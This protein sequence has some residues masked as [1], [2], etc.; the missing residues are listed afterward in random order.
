MIKV[1]AEE[2]E[3]MRTHIRNVAESMGRPF[4]YLDI[5]DRLRS[6]GLPYTKGQVRSNLP[7]VEGVEWIGVVRSPQPNSTLNLYCFLE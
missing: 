7:L 6:V 3:A 4:T 1:G 2:R 5:F